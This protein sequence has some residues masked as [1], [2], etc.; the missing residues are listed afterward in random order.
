MSA[1]QT[2]NFPAAPGIDIE[3]LEVR[4]GGFTLQVSGWSVPRGCCVAFIGRNGSGKTTFLDALL[5]LRRDTRMRGRML[6]A[7]ISAWHLRPRLRRRM[8]VI[9]QR[10]ALPYG[11]RVKDVVALHEHL[12]ERSSGLIGEELGIPEL[13][14]KF[15]DM[16]SRGEQ[17]RVELFLCLAHEPELII[18]DEPFT[19]LDQQFARV[20]AGILSR[21]THSTILMACHTELELSL[22]G[23]AVWMEQGVIRDSAPPHELRKSLLGDYRLRA[24]LRDESDARS[25]L[26]KLTASAGPGCGCTRDGREISL[27]GDESW[28]R[29]VPAWVPA[30]AIDAMQYGPTTLIDLLYRCAQLQSAAPAIRQVVSKVALS[31]A[32]SEP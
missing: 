32:A 18:L 26:S 27:T 29:S 30:A 16:L 11:F 7:D 9:L 23:M 3:E 20:A 15:F 19:G 17:Q 10:A 12:Y 5:G 4:T 24:T 21:L 31:C 13:A 14:E 22:A 8:G 1:Q 6:G 2:A 28:V 25:L